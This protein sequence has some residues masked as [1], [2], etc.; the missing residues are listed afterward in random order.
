MAFVGVQLYL[1]TS[2]LHVTSR[3]FARGVAPTETNLLLDC[4]AMVVVTV[5]S[6]LLIA[7][8]VKPRHDSRPP[9]AR[10]TATCERRAAT[11]SAVH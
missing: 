8:L 10:G 9:G 5:P 7:A 6:F 4:F 2:G 1:T 11:S 3:M